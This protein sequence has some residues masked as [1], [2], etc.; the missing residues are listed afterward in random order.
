MDIEISAS[1]L[2][3]VS[4]DLKARAQTACGK[5]KRH[6]LARYREEAESLL[7]LA[8]ILQNVIRGWGR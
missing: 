8:K 4:E 2:R 5:Y 6:R 3:A 7:M 1:I